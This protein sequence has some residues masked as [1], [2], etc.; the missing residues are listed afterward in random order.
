MQ[1]Q[2]TSTFTHGNKKLTYKVRK[3][4]KGYSYFIV[5]QDTNCKEAIGRATNDPAKAKSIF[6]QFKNYMKHESPHRVI[7]ELPAQCAAGHY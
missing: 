6:Y 5:L 1:Y 2:S 3:T 7:E 4:S